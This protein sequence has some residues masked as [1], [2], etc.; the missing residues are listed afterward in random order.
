MLFQGNISAISGRYGLGV[1]RLFIKLLKNKKLM[2]CTRIEKDYY[3]AP[4]IDKIICE[5]TKKNMIIDIGVSGG[6]EI[7]NI[8]HKASDLT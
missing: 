4:M 8:Y 6:I 5:E 1:K 7:K 2:A 3:G